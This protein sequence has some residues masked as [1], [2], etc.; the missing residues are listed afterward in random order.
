VLQISTVVSLQIDPII[1]GKYLGPS[2]VASIAITWKIFSV[3][4]LL[5][6]SASGGLWAQAT[7]KSES[8]DNFIL[9]D[10][11]TRNIKYAFFYSTVFAFLILI[12]GKYLVRIYSAKLPV[13]DTLMIVISSLL[14]ISLCVSLPISLILNGF[15][16]ERFLIATSLMAMVC[17][18]FASVFFVQFL[19]NGSG[20]LLGSLLAQTFCVII[21]AVIFFRPRDGGT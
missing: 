8:G 5:L 12:V 14:L 7:S 4:Y 10:L 6:V 2:E 18:Y 13:P 15:H 21:P 11:L 3:P 9:G 1:I 17:N 16:K 19:N 20:A